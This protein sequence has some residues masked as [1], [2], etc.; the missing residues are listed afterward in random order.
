LIESRLRSCASIDI[1]QCCLYSLDGN[2]LS[3]ELNSSLGCVYFLP[4]LRHHQEAATYGFDVRT[5]M[6][7]F[8]T[9]DGINEPAFSIKLIASLKQW[10]NNYWDFPNYVFRINI[11]EIDSQ[12]AL[13]ENSFQLRFQINRD[14]SP[15]LL[16]YE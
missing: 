3:P 14:N 15:I 9:R 12:Q 6:I 8:W 4:L 11:N 5:R 2:I 7:T 10:L 1:E 13:E 16:F